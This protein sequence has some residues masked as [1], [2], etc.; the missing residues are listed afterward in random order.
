MSGLESL[1]TIVIYISLVDIFMGVVGDCLSI[2]AR[3]EAVQVPS[4]IRVSS[5]VLLFQLRSINC[6]MILRLCMIL[7]KIAGN[8]VHLL[9]WR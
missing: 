9:E 5:A 3:V 6:L 8:I 7:Q 4:H 2:T 1:L